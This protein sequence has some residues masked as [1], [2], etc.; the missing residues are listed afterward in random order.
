MYVHLSGILFL[1]ILTGCGSEDKQAGPPASVS[2]N[3]K[4]TP[5]TLFAV[6]DHIPMRDAGV[7]YE[8]R[9][10]ALPQEYFA[11][12]LLRQ[13]DNNPTY[14]VLHGYE[15]TCIEATVRLPDQCATTVLNTQICS[16]PVTRPIIGRG[17]LDAL[18]CSSGNGTVVC[19][20]TSINPT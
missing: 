6:I 11:R 17:V 4:S 5:V 3:T 13:H 15:T 2:Y 18:G 10:V 16:V 20:C 14:T 12:L 19:S 7:S 8:Q 9:H 1:C